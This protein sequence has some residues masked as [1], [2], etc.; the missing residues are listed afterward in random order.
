MCLRQ[1]FRRV[2]QS[3]EYVKTHCKGLDIPFHSSIR[4]WMIK[5]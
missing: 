1:F 5:Q 3:P 4:K 2:S